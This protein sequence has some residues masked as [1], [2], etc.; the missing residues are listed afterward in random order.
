MEKT[1]RRYSV[2]F[3]VLLATLCLAGA[4]GAAKKPS[5]LA[6]GGAAKPR[7]TVSEFK[8]KTDER[9]MNVPT[10]AI[11]DMM[12]TE[13]SKA[14]L[15][16]LMERENLDEI[17]DE[18]NLGE[19]GLMDPETAPKVGKL[20]GASYMLSGAVTVYH[21]HSGGGVIAV[22]HLAGGAASKT[23]YVV[24]ELRIYNTETGEIMYAE[25]KE[26]KAKRESGGL[27]ALFPGF[28]IGG[29][30]G[31]YGGILASA[32]RDAVE[33]HVKEMKEYDW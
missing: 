10:K 21:Y 22:P 28:G 26:G 24:L 33:Q 15:F 13:L 8:N 32:T 9:G 19:S 3:C 2:L 7:L 1:L 5:P 29:G 16:S 17:F 31:S 4:A 23:A 18:I 6:G 27:V 11:R 25:V 14:R 12:V 30:G 20:K